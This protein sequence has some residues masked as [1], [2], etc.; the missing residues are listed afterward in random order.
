[1]R[2][3][4]S[5]LLAQQHYWQIVADGRREGGE[6]GGLQPRYALMPGRNICLKMA[7]T[8]LSCDSS[9]LEVSALHKRLLFG[10]PF[11]LLTIFMVGPF[12]ILGFPRH[13]RLTHTLGLL[14]DFADREDHRKMVTL[15]MRRSLLPAHG[16]FLDFYQLQSCSKGDSIT[17]YLNNVSRD[18]AAK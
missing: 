16:K 17:L 9:L 1:M 6:R 11:F 2:G 15:D 7:G 4:R 13:S 3:C 18:S 14:L 10:F 8:H 5:S 12:V